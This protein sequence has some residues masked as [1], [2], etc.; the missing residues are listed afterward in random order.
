MMRAIGGCKHDATREILQ[1]ILSPS[2]VLSRL[3]TVDA[4]LPPQPS[5]IR[6]LQNTGDDLTSGEPDPNTIQAPAKRTQLQTNRHWH[7]ATVVDD[8]NDPSS[9]ILPTQPTHHAI[10]TADDCID[11]LEDG[12][13]QTGC[14]GN[15]SDSRICGEE[16]WDL[17]TEDVDGS[18]V[19]DAHDEVD[20]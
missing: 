20:D 15:G 8:K 4:R 9:D 3:H 7:R 12:D 5:H 2:S 19:E 6:S 14:G 11:E 16:K 10:R 13:G 17:V 18:G 1:L